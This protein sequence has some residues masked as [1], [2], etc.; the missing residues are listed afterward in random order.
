MK[1]SRLSE[2]YRLEVNGWDF[3]HV[4]GGPRQIGFQHG[5]L[6][7]E[8]IDETI[9]RIRFWYGL[10]VK[11]DW[12]FFRENAE[13]LYLTHLPEEQRSEIEGIVEGLRARGIVFDFIDIVALNGWLDSQTMHYWLK[14]KGSLSPHAIPQPGGCS[15]FIAT[16]SYTNGNEIV[17][18]HNLWWCYLVGSMW[19]ILIHLEPEKGN[20]VL[21]QIL[22]GCITSSSDWCVS[23]SGLIVTETTITGTSQFDPQGAPYFSRARKAIQ[24]SADVDQWI[25]AMVQG[26]NGGYANDWL[27]GNLKTGEIAVLE[28]GAFH[29]KI[30]KKRDG[31][32]I[33]CNRALYPEVQEETVFDYANQRTSPA[34]RGK[35]LTE[36]M[37]ANKGRIDAAR[38]KE[39]LADHF[40]PSLEKETPSACS[41]CGHVE[42]DERGLEEWEWGPKFPGGTLDAKV[43]TGSLAAQGAT[44]ALWGKPCGT[45]FTADEFLN[46][47]LTYDAQRQ[48]LS[49]VKAYPWTFFNP[50]FH[51]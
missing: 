30:E 22:P 11:R 20:Q 40:D 51:D 36:L 9:K 50:H 32:F 31:Y 7:A 33:G 27:V 13:R 14:S 1:D 46:R 47:N 41:V 16:G 15:A 10:T 3:V 38:A 26:N 37:E 21:M 49:D 2:A 5:F 35:R 48:L 25:S 43:T 17:A 18:A 12:K 6:L 39:I 28:L 19:N 34:A 29:H 4:G 44:W 42:E 45:D 8:R 24:Y 23:S